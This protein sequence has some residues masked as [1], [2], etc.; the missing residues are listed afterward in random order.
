M[1][2]FL[3]NFMDVFFCQNDAPLQTAQK[4][5]RRTGFGFIYYCTDEDAVYLSFLVKK[6]IWK[7]PIAQNDSELLSPVFSDACL[8]PGILMDISL[9]DIRHRVDL[10]HFD[11]QSFKRISSSSKSL[12]FL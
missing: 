8:H 5:I 10:P 12:L 9:R 11:D 2:P 1:H 4:T 7:C 6:S 3:V